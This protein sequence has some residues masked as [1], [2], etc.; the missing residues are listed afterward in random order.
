MLGKVTFQKV[1]QPVAPST[2]AACSSSLP[3]ACISGISSRAMKGKV[4]KMVASTMPG[5]AKMILMSCSASQ[6]PNQPWAPNTSTY[7]RPATTGEIENGRSIRVIRKALPRN[8]NLA[9]HQAAATPNTRFT[10]TAI[11]AVIRVSLMADQA[12]GSCR[13]AT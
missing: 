2:M 5:T 12:S 9:M 7:I 6:G 1:C 13:P 8:S 4:T 3:C 11:S 10:G